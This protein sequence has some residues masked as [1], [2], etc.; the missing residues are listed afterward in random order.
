M[1]AE[2]IAFS[3]AVATDDE[4]TSTPFINSRGIVAFMLYFQFLLLEKKR[5]YFNEILN[6]S[7]DQMEI[8]LLPNWNISQGER[9]AK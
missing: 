6:W 8:L 3:G 2:L 5:I 7:I 1:D 4:F 9:K